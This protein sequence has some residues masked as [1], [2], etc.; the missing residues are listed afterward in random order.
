MVPMAMQMPRLDG[1]G[2]TTRIARAGVVDSSPIIEFT[3][4]ALAGRPHQKSGWPAECG[5]N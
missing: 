4:D 5:C 2:A 3:A 1:N